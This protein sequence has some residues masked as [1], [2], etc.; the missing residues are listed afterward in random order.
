MRASQRKRAA[1]QMPRS[2]GD[3]T[4]KLNFAERGEVSCFSHIAL[5]GRHFFRKN[6]LNS[7][8]SLNSTALVVAFA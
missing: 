2:I 4:I 3:K 5:V 6:R 8:F 7:E 1:L